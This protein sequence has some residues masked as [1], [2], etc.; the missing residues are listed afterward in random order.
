[1][2]VPVYFSC[3]WFF[4]VSGGRV[5]CSYAP[6]SSSCSCLGGWEVLG[7]FLSEV[8]IAAFAFFIIVYYCACV[9]FLSFQEMLGRRIHGKP[10]PRPVAVPVYGSYS[11]PW[12]FGGSQAF[13]HPLLIVFLFWRICPKSFLEEVFIAAFT[14]FFAV[15]CITGWVEEYTVTVRKT[16]HLWSDSQQAAFSQSLLVQVCLL[17]CSVS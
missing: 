14:F 5:G 2:A 9:F 6:S 4:S 16:N 8:F 13:L 1:M 15:C 17:R 10:S 11:V 7:S 3:L 12:G